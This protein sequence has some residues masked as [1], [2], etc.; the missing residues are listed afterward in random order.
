M[1]AADDPH[2]G[3]G[4]RVW[5]VTLP[6]GR[7]AI[8]KLYRRRRSRTKTCLRTALTALAGSKTPPGAA[9]RRATEERMLR[10]WAEVGCDVP[11]LIDP[12]DVGLA[13]GPALLMEC[14][15]GDTLL[16]WLRPRSWCSGAARAALLERFGATWAW[17]HRQALERHD[18]SLV[19]EHGS[20]D[21]VIVSGGRLVSFD[22]EQAFLPGRPVLPLVVKETLACLR[23]LAK[24][25]DDAGFADDL[26]A[27]VEGYG[28]RALLARIVA[29]GR[30]PASLLRRVVVA[31]DHAL[32][33][34]SRKRVSKRFLL[35]ALERALG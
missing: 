33:A 31:A 13:P 4:N 1:S 23:G 24:A 16:D 9:A 15:E 6:D 34:R 22:L 27:L 11:A 18:P 2:A 3:L 30:R 25:V 28:D 20:L 5:R 10:H 7:V 26:A 21:H 12:R 35:D 14:V 29:E 19:Q 8:Q 32:E 17:R